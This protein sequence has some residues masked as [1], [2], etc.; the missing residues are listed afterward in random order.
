MFYINMAEEPQQK[1]EKPKKPGFWERV[2][3][4]NRDMKNKKI[5]MLLRRKGVI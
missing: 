4:T 5:E 1:E 2:A 3:Q